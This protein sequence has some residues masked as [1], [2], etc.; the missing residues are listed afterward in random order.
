MKSLL[1]APALLLLC[2]SGCMK[3]REELVVMPDGSG[4]IILVFS[5][6]AKNEAA[7]FTEAELLS[8]DPDEL[9]DKVRGLVALAKPT[10]EEKD[11]VVKLRMAAYFDDLNAVK[12]MDEGEG[13][14][15]KPKQEFAFRREG[16]SF[17]LEITG[18]MLADEVPERGG[19]DP[20]LLK[21]RD[22]FFKQMFAGFEFRQDVRM[23]GKITAVDGFQTREDRVA[24]YA[25]GEK[26][27]QK[28]AD[29]KKIN[30]V[31]KFKAS[32]ARSEIT[33]AETAEFR[34]E[35]EK[36]KAD[37]V[38]LRKQMKKAAERRK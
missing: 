22:D 2:F 20:A 17:V 13:D 24:S 29:Q 9:Q 37:W 34:K 21:L 33:E 12:F 31:R 7:K 10:A 11:G 6:P 23:P 38:E 1:L 32:C 35:L 28:V 19:T 3:V 26:D 8:G 36:A 14:K 25:V 4:R 15:A 27:L 18:N 5:I 16:E 30:E